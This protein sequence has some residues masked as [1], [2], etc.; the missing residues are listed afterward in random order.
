MAEASQYRMLLCPPLCFC[1]LSK[2]LEDT[3]IDNLTWDWIWL[4][5]LCALKWLRQRRNSNRQCKGIELLQYL[6]MNISCRNNQK[7]LIV[8]IKMNWAKITY[9]GQGRKQIYSS[10]QDLLVEAHKNEH[11]QLPVFGLP[12]IHWS[13]QCHGWKDVSS[14]REL[15]AKTSRCRQDWIV[16]IQGRQWLLQM[17]LRPWW[18]A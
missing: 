7:S 15:Q 17:A 10:H 1:K 5:W 6:A 12:W 8:Y 3:I 13:L 11:Q 9:E 16:I 4:A 18:A 2:V 14:L